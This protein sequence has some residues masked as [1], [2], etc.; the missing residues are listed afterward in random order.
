[1]FKVEEKLADFIKKHILLICVVLTTLA[2]MYVR[3][4]MLNYESGDFIYFLKPWFEYLK[5]NGGLYALK[6]YPGDYNAPYMTLMALLTYLPFSG[7]KLIKGLSIIFDIV[8]AISG[9]AIVKELTKD[10]TKVFVAYMILLLVPAVVLNSAMWGQ[11]D[12]IYTSFVLLSILFLLKKKYIKS[13]V[14]LGLAFSFK[15]QFIFII[16]LYIL[17]YLSEKKFSILNFL[18]I[19]FVNCVLCLPAI[20]FGKPIVETLLIYANQTSTYKDSLTLNFPNI[21]NFINVSKEQV[22][23]MYKYGIVLTMIL[24]YC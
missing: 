10:K 18:I 17:Y 7:I 19:P 15:L 23:M 5:T 22:D 9:A 4:K 20:L 16:P 12:S 11:C 14:L 13:F 1:M 8:L 2:A 6:S 21:Y 24:F 3:Y